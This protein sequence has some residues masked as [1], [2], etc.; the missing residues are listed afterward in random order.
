M[1]DMVYIKLYKDFLNIAEALDDAGRGRLMLAILRYANG[2]PVAPMTGPEGI[3]F[4]AMKNQM[5]RDSDD[6]RSRAEISRENGRKGGRPRKQ[7]K[8]CKNLENP[9]VFDEKTENLYKEENKEKDDEKEKQKDDDVLNAAAKAD[10][11]VD[12]ALEN[13]K[14]ISRNNL[15]EFNAFRSRLTDDLICHAIDEACANGVPKY[16]YVRTILREYAQK[17]FRTVA[18]A[19]AGRTPPSRAPA[20]PA[21][22]YAQR[23]YRDEDFGDDFFIN[24]QPGWA[25]Q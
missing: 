5:D 9:S 24:L 20:N 4:L 10:P 18:E 19:E 13:L 6:Y 23:T 3:A 2:M 15:E 16:S 8:T 1:S 7:D 22:N 11:V 12:Y 21:L 14:G 17:G 25:N